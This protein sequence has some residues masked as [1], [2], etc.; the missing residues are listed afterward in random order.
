METKKLHCRENIFL[1]CIDAS[2]ANL[3]AYGLWLTQEIEGET[4]REEW[5]LG[6][7]ET[8]KCD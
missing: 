4:S 3:K 1:C 6:E 5:I 8:E 2:P 7:K